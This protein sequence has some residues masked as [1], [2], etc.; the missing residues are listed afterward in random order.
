MLIKTISP[1][2][3]L[4]KYKESD[5]YDVV[6]VSLIVTEQTLAINTECKVLFNNKLFPAI[7]ITLDNQETCS[8]Q[9]EIATRE[10]LVLKKEIDDLKKRLDCFDNIFTESEKEKM[11]TYAINTLNVLGSVE[12]LADLKVNGTN[13]LKTRSE[14]CLLYIGYPEVLIDPVQREILVF[15]LKSK[16]TSSK[17]L[18]ETLRKF[19]SIEQLKNFSYEKLLNEHPDIINASIEF[20]KSNRPNDLKFDPKESISVFLSDIKRKKKEVSM[21][22][23]ITIND[24]DESSSDVEEK[25][26]NQICS[27]EE[28]D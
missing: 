24:Q 28:D 12:N 18:R 11:I 26:C 15:Q 10:N 27:S 8:K 7:V 5:E 19:F 16:A 22:E 20:I 21:D 14:K 3:A 25:A 2:H 6:K 23:I 13:C 1:T 9:L 17:I 4:I